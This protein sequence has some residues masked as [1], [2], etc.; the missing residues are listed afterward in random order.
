[1]SRSI[2]D[3]RD[4]VRKYLQK[5]NTSQF[6]SVPARQTSDEER[7]ARLQG[8]QSRQDDEFPS[9]PTRK[10]SDQERLAR[11]LGNQSRQNTVPPIQNN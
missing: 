4:N 7:L 6:P 2:V 9:V 1:M 5:K 8:D 3:N 11:L 10:T